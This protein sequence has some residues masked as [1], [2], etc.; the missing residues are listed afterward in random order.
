MQIRQKDGTRLIC[1][2]F[3]AAAA[4]LFYHTYSFPKEFGL[5]ASEYG[6]AFFPR[7]LLAFI[8]LIAIILFFQATFRKNEANNRKRIVLSISQ[9]SRIAAIWVLCLMFYF[10]WNI[11]GYL[12][13]SLFFMLAAGLIL[14]IRNLI[15]LIFLTTTSPLMYLVFEKFLRVGL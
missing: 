11:F 12:P 10:G 4:L 7:F 2:L 14:G 3:I 9:F 15:I 5:V 1:L 6:S 13:S 8:M